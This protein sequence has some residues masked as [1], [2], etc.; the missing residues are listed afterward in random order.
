MPEHAQALA[1]LVAENREHLQA[2]LPAVVQLDSF[3][4]AQA[5]LQAA[6]ARA[7]SGEVL[8]WHVFSGTALCGSI[9]LK[10]IDTEDRKAKI[11][12][13]LGRQFQGRG[14]ASAAVRA[15]LAHAFGAL[16]LHR[17]ELQCAAGNGA[18]MALAERLGFA[19]EGVL[20]QAELLNGV[21]VDLHV[22]G[23]LQADCRP[24]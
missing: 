8:E 13:Y 24:D 22:F 20:R 10:D 6:C 5:Y 9:R 14:I 19:H 11:G 23:L 7:A 4:E 17:I 18:S 12:Y 16:Q 2:Y 1:T 21:F 3:G 15:V